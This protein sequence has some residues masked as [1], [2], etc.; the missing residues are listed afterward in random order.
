MRISDC[1]SDVCSSDPLAD[2][3]AAD[4]DDVADLRLVDRDRLDARRM[5]RQFAA[6]LAER[7]VHLA[8]DV[9][10]AVLGLRQR[11][12]EDFLRDAGDLDG[13]E[14]RRVGNECISPCR[15]RWSPYHYKKKQ[16]NESTIANKI[17]IESTT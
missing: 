4:A 6:N 7:L 10:A 3:L 14:E 12:F 17:L 2:H 16:N 13:S 11:L 5:R 9:R 15:S 1:S 8:Q